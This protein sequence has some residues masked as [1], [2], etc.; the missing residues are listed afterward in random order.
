[1]SDFKILAPS[2][3][4]D[5]MVE[6]KVSK[7]MWLYKGTLVAILKRPKDDTSS[8]TATLKVKTE[9]PGKVVDLLHSR[10]DRVKSG[11]L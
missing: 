5:Y 4:G 7:G 6:F 8:N 10:G 3:V 1:M 9:L 2:F 11:Y